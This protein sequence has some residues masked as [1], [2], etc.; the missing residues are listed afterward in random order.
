MEFEHIEKAKDSFKF[1]SKIISTCL[2]FVAVGMM[3][4]AVGLIYYEINSAKNSCRDLDM[5]YEFKIP[6][7]HLCNS[8]SYFKYNDGEWDF[9][10]EFNASEINFTR[11]IFP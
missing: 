9:E 6:Y 11:I 3:L 2:I 4:F 10:R 7:E 5:E 8:Q 1:N